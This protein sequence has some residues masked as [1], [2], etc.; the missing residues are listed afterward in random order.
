VNLKA[1][2]LLAILVFVPAHGW[3]ADPVRIGVLLSMDGPAGCQGRDAWKGI[4]SAHRLQPKVLGRQVQL[5][6]ANAHSEP[7][8]A[9]CAFFRLVEREKVCAV[10]GD[11]TASCTFAAAGAAN[12]H[13]IPLVSLS[14]PVARRGASLGYT[15]WTGIPAEHLGRRCAVMC[16]TVLRAGTVAII[17]DNSQEFS[18]R[19][20]TCF[21]ETFKSHGGQ[22]V[23]RSGL[24]AAQLNADTNLELVRRARPDALI[25]VLFPDRCA[26]LVNQARDLGIE[27][28][29]LA[30][31]GVNHRNLL[32]IEGRIVEPI[33]V[34]VPPIG[35]TVGSRGTLPLVPQ[36]LLN[37]SPVNRPCE[38]AG[39][40]AY[41]SL[42]RAVQR[43]QSVNSATIHRSISELHRADA[44]TGDRHE[45][46]LWNR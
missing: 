16:R 32:H 23:H 18:V 22:V 40:D 24:H 39:A 14:G 10:I 44:T 34:P 35:T 27:A 11:V 31:N 13:K 2:T 38:R 8:Q 46:L 17:Q 21:A 20:A 41:L 25:F 12:M 37:R 29:I 36:E 19:L 15:V 5:V 45:R 1:Y 30:V 9:A 43:T 26:L 4:C 33:Y 3:T 42:L 7:S 6:P 28:S